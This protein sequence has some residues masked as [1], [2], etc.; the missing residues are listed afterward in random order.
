MTDL[1]KNQIIIV[2]MLRDNM[3]FNDAVT[4]LEEA[5]DR[6]SAGDDP[7]EVLVDEFGLEPD[8]IFDLLYD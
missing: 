5:R 7:E 8:Y 3:S 1:T 4:S 6:I 2:L